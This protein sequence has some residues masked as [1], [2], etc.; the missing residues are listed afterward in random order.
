MRQCVR[1][2]PKCVDKSGMLLI[3]GGAKRKHDDADL[4]DEDELI[5]L[6]NSVED[7]EGGKKRRKG[8]G[9]KGK[10]KGNGKKG[11]GAG[12]SEPSAPSEMPPPP[13]PDQTQ[14]PR[15]RKVPGDG[16]AE[17]PQPK[18]KS[19][20]PSQKDT[21]KDLMIVQLSFSN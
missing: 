6:Q 3:K 7:G 17:I 13:L 20:R 2:D 16:E 8:K 15:K 9:K 21:S 4:Y 19:S 12:S 14:K 11:K 1:D 18:R 10:G 5:K